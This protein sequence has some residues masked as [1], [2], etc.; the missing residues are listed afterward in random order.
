MI[1]LLLRLLFGPPYKPRRPS[2]DDGWCDVWTGT[3]VER[4]RYRK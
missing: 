4:R 3:H 1:R 2:W